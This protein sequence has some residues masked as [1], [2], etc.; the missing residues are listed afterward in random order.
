[1][2]NEELRAQ[3]AESELPV[4]KRFEKYE[5][6]EQYVGPMFGEKSE[7][8]SPVA[9]ALEKAL[10]IDRDAKSQDCCGNCCDSNCSC[11]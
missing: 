9:S 2:T 5:D 11:T 1:M 7:A 6:S 3:V 10:G 4:L 8:V